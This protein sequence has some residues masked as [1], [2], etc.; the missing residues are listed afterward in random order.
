MRKSAIL[1]AL[2]AGALTGAPQMALA[3]VG[4]VGELAGHSHLLGYGALA[5]A[6][7]LAA[8]A[9]RGRKAKPQ[10]S[11]TAEEAAGEADAAEGKA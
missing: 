11:E 8:L 9:A 7:V 1:A 6:A 2:A 10:E 4:H 3:H 5:A